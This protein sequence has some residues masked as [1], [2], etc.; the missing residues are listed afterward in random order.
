MG[1]FAAVVVA[2]AVAAWMARR[3][4]PREA[5]LPWS[6]PDVARMQGT[7]MSGMGAVSITGL[8]LILSFASRGTGDAS[9]LGLDTVAIMFGIA[10]GSFIQTFYALSLLPDR[11]VVGERIFRFYYGLTTTLQSRT[12]IL[13]IVG[14]ST[15]VEFY[16]LTK[17]VATITPLIPGSLIAVFVVTS[18]VAHA[19]GLM[20]FQECAVVALI[21]LALGLA[22]YLTMKGMGVRE[23]D[24]A[25]NMT[26]LYAVI[27]VNAFATIGMV[28]MTPGMPRLRAFIER[29]ARFL[30]ILEMQITVLSITFLWMSVMRVV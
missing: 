11:E 27:N 6:L 3:G 5:P 18:M 21:G 13:L 16:G 24:G 14:Q 1:F 29:H 22:F 23:A 17:A 20:R 8:V 2:V 25:L 10:F 26:V 28:L 30:T 9:T 4:E 19:M 12:I 7:L 15:F